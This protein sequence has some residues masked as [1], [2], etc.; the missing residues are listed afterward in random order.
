MSK[1][2]KRIMKNK[3]ALAIALALGCSMMSVASAA[4]IDMNAGEYADGI[5][6]TDKNYTSG[7]ND[8][9]MYTYDA[10]TGKLL[11]GQLHLTEDAWKAR[12][13]GA[14]MV[15]ATDLPD[16]SSTTVNKIFQLLTE[17]Y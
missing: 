17:K 8:D 15:K 5:T 7:I 1:S 6:V 12:M 16:L 9:F 10:G 3:V 11:G 14:L 2:K 4:T 13:N